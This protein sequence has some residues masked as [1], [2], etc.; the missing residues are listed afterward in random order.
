[1]R[2]IMKKLNKYSIKSKKKQKAMG[3]SNK[4]DADKRY[5]FVAGD[6]LTKKCL[7]NF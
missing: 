3:R 1:M 2:I 6:I 4:A 5:I 7:K